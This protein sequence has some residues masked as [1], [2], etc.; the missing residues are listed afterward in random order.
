MRFTKVF[1]W[2][3]LLFVM[4][5][6]VMAYNIKITPTD[7]YKDSDDMCHVKLTI[8]D[9]DSSQAS[10][11][12]SLNWDSTPCTAD[13]HCD[14]WERVYSFEEDSQT[15]SVIVTSEYW[16]VNSDTTSSNACYLKMFIKD[17]NDY[18]SLASVGEISW[19]ESDCDSSTDCD[20]DTISRDI[21]ELTDLNTACSSTSATPKIN[22]TCIVP[23]TSVTCPAMPEIPACPACTCTDEA[24]PACTCAAT[25]LTPLT[26]EPLNIKLDL[27]QVI[28]LAA[29]AVVA[30]VV[31]YY[32]GTQ[33]GGGGAQ[34]VG[35]ST[36]QYAQLPPSR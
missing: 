2:S 10:S 21:G 11:T 20:K 19:A 1:M 4:I 36:Q 5:G 13:N 3:I 31:T 33:Q 35:H 28:I 26:R 7:N 23:A 34:S 12:Y 25:D 14:G 16:S 27:M 29:G 18:N 30:A 24:C 9:T 22:V 8:R 32:L 6:S 15:Y 17:V